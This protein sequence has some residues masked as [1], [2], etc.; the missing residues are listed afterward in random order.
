[1]F[2]LCFKNEMALMQVMYGEMER[3]LVGTL[4]DVFALQR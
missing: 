3:P 1:M 4:V 2:P